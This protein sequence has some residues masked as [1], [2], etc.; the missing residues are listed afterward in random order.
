[1]F[2]RTVDKVL[3]LLN[4]LLKVG[5]H[6]VKPR[7][8]IWRQFSVRQNLFDSIGTKSA[9]T[10]EISR[11]GQG[12]L[13]IGTLGDFL[14]IHCPENVLGKDVSSISHGQSGTAGT[15]LG[16]DDFVSTKL[17]SDGNGL[18]IFRRRIK[19]RDL[20]VQ[21]KN[22]S[23]RV[24]SN[25]S[26]VDRGRVNTHVGSSKGIGT[27]NVQSCDTTQFGGIVDTCLLQDFSGNGDSTVDGVTNN[28]QDGVGAKLGTAFY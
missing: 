6:L 19:A 13:H 20:G 11:I 27:H 22:G 26:H 9:G 12:A 1:M 5:K 23:T 14:T 18:Q 2:L 25:D 10:R 24:S 17:S 21:G 7:L 28:S 3:S 16:L 15:C 4:L 8:L